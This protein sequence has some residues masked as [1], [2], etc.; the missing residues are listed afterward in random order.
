MTNRIPEQRL[1]WTELTTFL[2]NKFRPMNQ[3][4][5]N[6]IHYLE[7]GDD[8]VKFFLELYE[9]ISSIDHG[10]RINPFSP[11]YMILKVVYL[12]LK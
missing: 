1:R 7:E 9:K 11:V 12:E 10:E 5:Y 4:I 8:K 6:S 2:E 3:E